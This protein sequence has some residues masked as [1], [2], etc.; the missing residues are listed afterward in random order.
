[1]EDSHLLTLVMELD[2]LTS[3]AQPDEQRVG[4]LNAIII[5]NRLDDSENVPAWLVE[6]FDAL[7]HKQPV[8]P[9]DLILLARD[10]SLTYHFLAELADV[11]DMDYIEGGDYLAIQ[12]PTIDLEAII[13]LGENNYSVRLI[14]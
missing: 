6:L 8:P 13:S 1:M 3:G 5:N 4:E 12:F 11:V 2:R 7:V 14:E 10:G 9:T